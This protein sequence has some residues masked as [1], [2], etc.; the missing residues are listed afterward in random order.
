MYD[1]G[2]VEG[3]R[4]RVASRWDGDHAVPAVGTQGDSL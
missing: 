3:E 2:R 4:E 1:V